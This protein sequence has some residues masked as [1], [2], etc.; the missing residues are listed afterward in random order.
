MCVCAQYLGSVIIKNLHGK[1]SA[2]EACLKLRVSNNM[3]HYFNNP[4]PNLEFVQTST[5]NMQKIPDIL[6]SIS[7][8]GVKFMDAQSKVCSCDYS[9][10]QGSQYLDMIIK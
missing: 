4:L 1:Q 5:A 10:M 3:A 2:E 7:W 6:L 8:K 9:Q